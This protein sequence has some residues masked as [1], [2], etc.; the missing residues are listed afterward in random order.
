MDNWPFNFVESFS[1]LTVHL[2]K[3]C[4]D[5]YFTKFQKKRLNFWG[6][7]QI[8]WRCQ[9]VLSTKMVAMADM[10]F[11]LIILESHLFDF[12]SD[13]WDNFFFKSHLFYFFILMGK[14]M[15]F[16]NLICFTFS[17][18]WDKILLSK[19]LFSFIFFRLM[20]GG[21]FYHLQNLIS[22]TSSIILK[23]HLFYFF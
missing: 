12:L 9:R 18:W 11:S 5:V 23:S 15:L 1:L 8:C 14:V 20:G 13:W 22:F 2:F 16:F 19:N 6:N 21:S 7:C 3:I 10:F 4:I 17:D